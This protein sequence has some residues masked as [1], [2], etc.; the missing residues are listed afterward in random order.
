MTRAEAG[1]FSLRNL[2]MIPV[3]NLRDLRNTLDV[4]LSSLS[5]DSYHRA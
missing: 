1:A 3:R 2:V 4:F 5:S